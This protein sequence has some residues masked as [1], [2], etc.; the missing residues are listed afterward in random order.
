MDNG[1]KSDVSRRAFLKDTA[2]AAAGVTT[3]TLLQPRHVRGSEANSMIGLG[4]IGTGGRGSHDGRNLVRTGKVKVIALADYFDFQMKEPAEQ[5]DV[6][7][8]RCFSGLDGYKAVLA[9][10]DIDAVLLTTP[11]YFRPIHFK[12]AV[13]AGKHAFAEKPIA[14]DPWGCQEFLKAGKTAAEKKITVGAGL[15]SRYEPGHQEV[16]KLIHE[17][18]I[19][20]PVIGHSKR[21]GGD[22]WRHERPASFTELDHQIRHWLYYL[23]GSGDFIVEMHVHNLDVFNWFTGMLPVSAVGKGGRMVRLDVGDIYDHINVIYE[24]P[25]GFHLAHTGTQIPTGY[26]GGDK[27]IIGSEGSYDTSTGLYTKDKQRV[28]HGG[29]QNADQEEMRQFVASILGEASYINNSEYVTTSTFTCILGRTAAYSGQ[30][31]TWKELWDS[32]KRIEIPT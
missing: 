8:S 4:I 6:D 24:Y 32:G 30:K 10:K 13:E 29:I 14:V 12:A 5:F 28:K 2:I 11:P 25:N 7:P 3:F 19:G 18:A 31:V 20:K 21:M 9:L 15:Q 1:K 16:A 17:G 22:L 23:W 26:S 27:Q